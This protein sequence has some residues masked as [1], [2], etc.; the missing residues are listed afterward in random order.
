[1]R[2]G[3]GMSEGFPSNTAAA[4]V[5]E[6]D[7]AAKVAHKIARSKG[8]HD[9]PRE[10]GTFIAL[11]HGELSEALEALRQGNPESQKIPG[12]SHVEEELADV[13][14]RILDYQGLRGLD[15]GGAILA[16]MSHNIGRSKRHGGKRF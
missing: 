1:M 3:D 16:K 9:E 8:W 15:I 2:Q 14:I 7:H 12:F 4:F 5:A 10:D 13:V 6:W 11:M